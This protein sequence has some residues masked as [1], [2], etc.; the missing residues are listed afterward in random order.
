MQFRRRAAVMA[1]Q[2][3][4][5]ASTGLLVFNDRAWS[6]D[7]IEP[8]PVGATGGN[9]FEV[10]C[11]PNTFL[12]GLRGNTGDQ[13]GII[14][15]MQLICAPFTPGR[16]VADHTNFEVGA[17]F[18]Q[19]SWMGAGTGGSFKTTSCTTGTGFVKEIR[20]NT[21]VYNNTKL[22]EHIQLECR[23]LADHSSVRVFGYIARGSPHIH[24]CSGSSF[25]V[26]FHGRVGLYL[27]AI[28]AVCAGMP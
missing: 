9:H 27:D 3:A 1:F 23:D 18:D 17:R 26:G 19:G 10:I 21:A 12:L 25:L 22:I 4:V 14:E 7:Y 2:M 11:P 20:F 15:K 16:P 5:S 28:G 13:G 6:Y 24:T 8:D